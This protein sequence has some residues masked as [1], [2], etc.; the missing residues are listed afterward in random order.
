MAYYDAPRQLRKITKLI[1]K[2]YDLLLVGRNLSCILISEYFKFV[3]ISFEGAGP[4]GSGPNSEND[5]P[6]EVRLGG[7]TSKI[8]CLHKLELVGFAEK[9]FFFL[10]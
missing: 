9:D 3:F 4:C 7:E 5:D 10:N 8:R 1:Q 6:R 2:G